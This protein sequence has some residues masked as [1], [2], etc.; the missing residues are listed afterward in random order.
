MKKYNRVMLGRGGKFA[1]MCK[2]EGYIGAY[3]DIKVDLSDSLYDNWRDFNT[4]FIPVWMDYLRTGLVERFPTLIVCG[5]VMLVA[6]LM[7]VAGVILSTLRQQDRRD[8]EFKLV[9]VAWMKK[10]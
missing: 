5:I 3:F 2:D 1:K 9:Q 6:L 7:F 4:K 8:F 10:R